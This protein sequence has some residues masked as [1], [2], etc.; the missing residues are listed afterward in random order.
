MLFSEDAG[1]TSVALGGIAEHLLLR[2]QAAGE[3]DHFGGVNRAKEYGHPYAFREMF[4]DFAAHPDARDRQAAV[5]L[6]RRLVEEV[7]EELPS[8]ENGGW[9]DWQKKRFYPAWQ[10]IKWYLGPLGNPALRKNSNL[11]I[12]NEAAYSLCLLKR[13]SVETL[14]S[15]FCYI[16]SRL[17]H[18]GNHFLLRWRCKIQQFSNRFGLPK[19]ARF[20]RILKK[21]GRGNLQR[22]AQVDKYRQAGDLGSALDLAQVGGIDAAQLGQSFRSE[23]T[24]LSAQVD[25]FSQMQ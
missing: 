22:I 16:Q 2:Q 13:S 24:V 15:F 11:L 4:Y 17:E 6:L 20:H 8:A 19:T 1:V 18:C 14:C 23:S 5:E 12:C 9:L 3:Q 25:S 21:I 10:R 7:S